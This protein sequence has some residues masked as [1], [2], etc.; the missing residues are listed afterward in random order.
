MFW[1]HLKINWPLATAALLLL[2]YLPYVLVS[3]VFYTNQGSIL[4][5]DNPQR[6]WRWVSGMSVL[7]GVSLIVLVGTYLLDPSR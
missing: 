5:S 4:R 3:G 7:L 1:H 2:L 6:Y